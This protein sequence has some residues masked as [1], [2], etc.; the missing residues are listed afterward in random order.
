MQLYSYWQNE[1]P[2]IMIT[3]CWKHRI[4]TEYIPSIMRLFC[5]SVFFVVEWNNWFARTLQGY[6]TGTGA[7]APVPV[8]YM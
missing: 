4:E 7:I 5:I 6:F 3:Q 8:K 2:L 1:L